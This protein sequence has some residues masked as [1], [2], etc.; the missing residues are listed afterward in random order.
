MNLK[1]ISFYLSLFCF[2]ISFLSFIN[3]LYASY[4]DYFLSIDTYFTTL[5]IS[6]VIGS[7]LFYFGKNSQKNINFIEQLI[8]IIMTYLLTSLLVALPFYLSNYQVTFLNGIFESISGL[9]GTGFSIFKN[10]KYLDPTLILWRSSS[11]WIGGLYFLIFLIIIFSNKSFNYKMTNLTYS[12][13]NNFNT[14]ENVKDNILKIF[15][16][17]SVLSIII[18][19]LLNVSGVRLFNSLNMSMTLISGGGFLPTDF[20]GKIISTNLQKIIFIFAL[21]ISMLNFYL[22]INIFNKKILVKDHKEDLYLIILPLILFAFIYFTNYKGIDIIISV[23][24][25]LANSGLTVVQSGNNLSLYFLLITII[26]GSLISNTSG[27]KLTRFYILLKITSLEIIKLI[28]PNSVINKTIF[29]SDKKISDE[30]IKI[31][32]LIFISF[33][34]SLL[35]LSSFLVIDDIGFEK[36]FKLSILTLTNTVNSEMFNM[37]NV[38]FTNLLTSS[39]IS[40]ILF[41]IIGKIE[42][43]SVFLIFK[44]ILFK[45]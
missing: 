28:S 29:N 22:A 45:D 5:I 4:F 15:I 33:F 41:M 43:I 23:I 8:T 36:S 9:T 24:S 39:K 19:S 25:S 42:L 2:P 27:I 35:I 1:G 20:I 12:G 40:L 6:F 7:G 31:S 44:K 32:F 16:I 13:E 10:I 17:Y 18:L 30:N 3:I 11:Q 21:I 37:Q 38:N 14:K 26:G 34:L